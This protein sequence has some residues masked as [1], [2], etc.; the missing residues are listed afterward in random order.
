MREINNIR[1]IELFNSVWTLLR[2]IDEQ[3]RSIK[4]IPLI[5][6]QQR[7]TSQQ[8]IRP[9]GDNVFEQQ[10]TMKA[11]LGREQVLKINEQE[12]QVRRVELR[13]IYGFDV[14]G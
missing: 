8:D 4:D 13:T 12:R 5:E 14:D 10:R 1:K 2:F 3:E 7:L 9:D 6:Y 11:M